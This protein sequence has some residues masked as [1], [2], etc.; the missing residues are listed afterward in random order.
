MGGRALLSSPHRCS[1]LSVCTRGASP[2]ALPQHLPQQMEEMQTSICLSSPLNYDSLQT[3]W[4]SRM[5]GF[6]VAAVNLILKTFFRSKSPDLKLAYVKS[7]E[8]PTEN[9][10]LCSLSCP[11]I[12]PEPGC[13]HAEAGSA[14]LLPKVGAQTELHGPLPGDFLCP[15]CFLP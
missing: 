14:R 5:L 6:T 10:P 8:D 1:T 3:P 4:D 11:L 9:P 15:V 2:L 12:Q 7:S 13:G